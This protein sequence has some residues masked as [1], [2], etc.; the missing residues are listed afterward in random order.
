MIR[1]TFDPVIELY[2]TL[3]AA[4]PA[5]PAPLGPDNST[6]GVPFSMS[7]PVP[8][9]ANTQLDVTAVADHGYTGTCTVY[10][11]RQ[12]LAMVWAT[13]QLSPPT[14]DGGVFT[15]EEVRTAL[16]T[17]YGALFDNLELPTTPFVPGP[18]PGTVTWVMP[19]SALL[20]TGALDIVL[21]ESTRYPP[22][23]EVLTTL[24]LD[25]LTPPI[26]I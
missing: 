8:D 2:R 25:G 20:L 5:L 24:A 16:S 9:G 23:D 15:W 4:N 11:R 19:A 1:V 3:N 10:Y 6:L 13:T 17:K 21:T 12:D 26:A 22:L 7:T 18:L 14:I